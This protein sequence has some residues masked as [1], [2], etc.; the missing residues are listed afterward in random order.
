MKKEKALRRSD[1]FFVKKNKNILH[2]LFES[3]Y[4][5]CYYNYTLLVIFGYYFRA[6]RDMIAR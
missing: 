6:F 1:C 3:I 2:I 4:D 5:L